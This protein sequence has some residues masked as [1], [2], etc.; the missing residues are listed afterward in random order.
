MSNA[1]SEDSQPKFISNPLLGF[2]GVMASVLGIII[3][4]YFYIEGKE[5]HQL[6]YYVD[7]A[8][9]AVFESGKVPRLTANYNGK[10]IQG[11][12]TVTQIAI[13]NQGKLPIR[14]SDILKPIVLN[15]HAPILE[16]T[17][18]KPGRDVTQLSIDTAGIQDGRIPIS[19]SILEKNDGGV[20]QVVY[21]GTPSY[22]AINVTGV[23]EGQKEISQ[24]KILSRRDWWSKLGFALFLAL[25]LV[26]FTIMLTKSGDGGCVMWIISGF[27]ICFSSLVMTLVITDLLQPSA[28]PF[29][30]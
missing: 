4:I 15:V 2:I 13:W 5:A 11:D 18:K 8:V 12:I 25:L 22:Y 28:P 14:K 1:T 27:G 16:A 3:T 9:S 30:F 29:S 7:P 6:T 20:I 10:I 21:A 26:T 23:V 19:W 17:V 24:L